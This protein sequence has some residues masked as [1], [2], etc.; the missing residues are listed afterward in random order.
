MEISFVLN[1]NTLVTGQ[2]V[3]DLEKAI[4]A[5]VSF[6]FRS[7]EIKGQDFIDIGFIVTYSKVLD[8]TFK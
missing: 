3:E 7:K 5:D 4:K 8:R 1:K 6:K 2:E